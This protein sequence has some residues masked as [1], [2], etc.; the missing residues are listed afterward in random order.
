MF[1]GQII[2]TQLDGIQHQRCRLEIADNTEN[3]GIPCDQ[4]T[5]AF[6]IMIL[7]LTL[8]FLNFNNNTFGNPLV[9]PSLEYNIDKKTLQFYYT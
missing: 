2:K 8:E 3:V 4:Q 1:P 7:G 5:S 9:W 6:M